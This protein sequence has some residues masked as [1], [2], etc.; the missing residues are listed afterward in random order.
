MSAGT[1]SLAM[2]VAAAVVV[3]AVAVGTTVMVVRKDDRNV[4]VAAITK[5]NAQ[6]R[7]KMVAYAT[8]VRDNDTGPEPARNERWFR[9]MAEWQDYTFLHFDGDENFDD[10]SDDTQVAMFKGSAEDMAEADN[11]GFFVPGNSTTWASGIKDKKVNGDKVARPKSSNWIASANLIASESERLGPDANTVIVA[12]LGYDAPVFEFSPGGLL[13]ALFG[14][15]PASSMFA[16]QG[17]KTLADHVKRFTAASQHVTLIAHSYGGAVVGYSL[18]KYKAPGVN[19]VVGGGVPG[20]AMQLHSSE[21]CDGY[22]G[23]GTPLPSKAAYTRQCI[24]EVGQ[25]HFWA[26]QAEDDWLVGKGTGVNGNGGV[27]DQFSGNDKCGFF[28]DTLHGNNF[29]AHEM[30]TK[31]HGYV[32]VTEHGEYF[33][34]NNGQVPLTVVNTA[35][36]VLGNYDSVHLEGAAPD[37]QFPGETKPGR[38]KPTPDGQ[39]PVETTITTAPLTT[40]TS[41]PVGVVETATI[42]ATEAAE[43]CQRYETAAALLDILV[44][45]GI[46]ISPDDDVSARSLGSSGVT[47][48]S[49]SDYGGCVVPNSGGA[50]FDVPTGGTIYVSVAPGLTNAASVVLGIFFRKQ[51]GNVCSSIDLSNPNSPESYAAA[52]RREIFVAGQNFYVMFDTF[53]L[54]DAAIALMG[55]AATAVGGKL[56][57]PSY[58]CS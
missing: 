10:G 49:P 4:Q 38:R 15:S 52:S 47:F 31:G 11:V 20:L 9:Q 56:V 33:N 26:M 37:V 50:A 58:I 54:T 42:C 36:V 1:G 19:D 46:C 21:G 44:A 29:G 14:A 17:G 24:T 57:S 34:K 43:Q 55:R 23:D 5:A 39:D 2:K 18:W 13:K 51:R 35:Y 22:S 7:A 40:T 16:N 12:W 53:Q 48:T 8:W 30:E 41:V 45:S 6:A 32:K 25:A 3:T 27:C 28:G